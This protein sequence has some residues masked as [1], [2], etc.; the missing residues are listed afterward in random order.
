M[1]NFRVEPVES[2]LEL[3]LALLEPEALAEPERYRVAVFVE[4]SSD[5]A[6]AITVA[7]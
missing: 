6:S 7:G 3:G 5:I 2:E 4:Q 1:G